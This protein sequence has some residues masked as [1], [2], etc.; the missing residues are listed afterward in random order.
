[1]KLVPG[2]NMVNTTFWST[3]KDFNVANNFMKANEWRNSF[4]ICKTVKNNIDIEIEQLNPYNEK[5]VLF[6]PFTEFRIEKVLSG[7]KYGKKIFTIILTDL[8]KRNFVNAENMKVE[9]I[10]NFG[11]K[12]KVEKCLK[13]DVGELEGIKEIFKNLGFE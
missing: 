13:S 4:I 10:K 9:N 5:E 2:T 11:L 7:M 8:G 6:L 12:N 1:M 3:S